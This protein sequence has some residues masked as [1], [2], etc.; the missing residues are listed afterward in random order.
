M[1]DP[2]KTIPYS[3]P[4]VNTAAGE[5]AAAAANAAPAATKTDVTVEPTTGLAQGPQ[6][7]RHSRHS[8]AAAAYQSR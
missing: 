8:A 6:S 4:V 3:I 2:K 7:R 1:T 5:L